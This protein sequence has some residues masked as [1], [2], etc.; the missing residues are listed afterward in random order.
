MESFA[1]VCKHL[2]TKKKH[3]SFIINTARIGEMRNRWFIAPL[4]KEKAKKNASM[5][6]KFNQV[7]AK[8]NLPSSIPVESFHFFRGFYVS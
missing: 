3:E 5:N 6:K 1:S 4:S 2:E 8:E 7:A